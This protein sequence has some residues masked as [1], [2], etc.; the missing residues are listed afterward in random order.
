MKAAKIKSLPTYIRQ[1]IR[2]KGRTEHNG[3]GVYDMYTPDASWDQ[4]VAGALKVAAKLDAAGQLECMT[5]QQ[6]KGEFV[7]IVVIAKKSAM[8]DRLG[9]YRTLEL[10][11]DWGLT[12]TF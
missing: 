6:V 10:N 3:R 12:V 2:L 4:L 1:T 11:K 9:N 7:N 8:S 5:Q